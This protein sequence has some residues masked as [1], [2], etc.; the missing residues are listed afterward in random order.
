MAA[1]NNPDLHHFKIFHKLVSDLP[2]IFYALDEDWI[3]TLSEGKGLE[4]IDLKPGQVLGL[5]A[6]DVYHDQPDVLES[7]SRAFQG[8][9]IHT[10]FHLGELYLENFI[11]P[12]YSSSNKIEG[13]IGAAINITQRKIIELNLEKSQ[14]MQQAIIDSI[15]G[16]LYLYNENGELVF[17]NKTHELL[18]GYT[19][20]ELDHFPLSSWYKDD[21]ESLQRVTDGLSTTTLNGYGEAEANL[22]LKNGT[23]IPFYFTACPLKI[24]DQNYFVGIGIDISRQKT[25]EDALLLMNHTL[26]DKVASRT[27]EL[28][29]SN[30]ELTA[31]NEEMMAMNEELTAANEEITAMNEEL[32]E[33]NERIIEMKDYLVESEKLAALGALVAGVAHEVNTPLGV[34]ITAS[35]HISNIADE[36]MTKIADPNFDQAALVDYL[37]DI[38]KAALIIEKNLSRAGKLTHSFKQLSVDQIS[39][40]KRVFNVGEYLEEILI[41]LS[42]SFKKTNI[43]IKTEY[44]ETIF[45]NGSPGAFAQ[46]ITNLLMNSLSHAYKQYEH[47]IINIKLEYEQDHVKITFSDDGHGMTPETLSKIYEPFFT[48]RRDLGGTGLGLAIV[49]SIITQQFS[50]TIQC[51]SKLE[52][53]TTFTI[54]LS[55]GG[56]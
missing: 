53:G 54:I 1:S 9:V 19:S 22:R 38:R 23:K 18:T 27:N 46:I 13:V 6:K 45:L 24:E 26:E 7:L 15:P 35:S 42:P 20:S 8:E 28:S 40:P 34:G 33:S 10:E 25:A 41:S 29:Q 48:T 51:T 37:A 21:P 11:V 5:C 3:F 49:Y 17:W 52:V 31:L 32:S 44:K 50:G 30:E 56:N 39:E 14:Q 47:G 36:L 4:A 2:M 55:Q 43:Q 16:M 12:I